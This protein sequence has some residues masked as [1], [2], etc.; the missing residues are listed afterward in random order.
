MDLQKKSGQINLSLLTYDNQQALKQQYRKQVLRVDELFDQI[1]L[2]GMEFNSS[3]LY[4]AL[5][6]YDV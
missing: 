2:P 4:S 3:N 5:T 6:K 1:G